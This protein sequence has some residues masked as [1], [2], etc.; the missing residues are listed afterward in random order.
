MSYIPP[1]RDNVVFNF[2]SADT[3]SAPNRD[4]VVFNFISGYEAIGVGKIGLKGSSTVEETYQA[5]GSGKIGLKGYSLSGKVIVDHTGIGKIGLKGSSATQ[6]IPNHIGAG[7]IGLNGQSI[8]GKGYNF[9]GIGKIGLKGSSLIE[10]NFRTIGVGKIG[11]KGSSLIETN[12]RTTGVGKIGL[13]GSNLV[14]WTHQATGTGKIGLSGSS[15]TEIGIVEIAQNPISTHYRCYLDD[16]ELPIK[17]FQFRI[18][19]IRKFGSVVLPGAAYYAAAIN[20]RLNGNLRV[21]R[22]YNYND[23]SNLLF[24]MFELPFNSIRLDQGGLSGLTATLSGSDVTVAGN[25]QTIELFD[26]IYYSSTD[27][28]SRRYRCQLDPRIRPGDT[29]QINGESFIIE[30]IIWYVD[31]KTAIAEISEAA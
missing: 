28:T 5:I 18:N 10:A 22:I 26:P 7:K 24:I 14:E 21:E 30:E 9:I 2:D 25:A 4:N 31:V 29:A 19:S 17:S 23:G 8:T 15:L 20:A 13:K 27:G 16:L 12:F 1:S 11:L 6:Y 3:Y